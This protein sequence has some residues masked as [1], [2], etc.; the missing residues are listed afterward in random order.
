MVRERHPST[1]S[2]ED[3]RELIVWAVECCERLLP[4]FTAAVPDD[5]RPRTALDGALAF[6]RG[7]LRIGVARK[8]AASCHAAARAAPTRAAVAVARM[9]G[10]ATAVAHMGSHARGIPYY[11]H[12]ALPSDE[13]ETEVAWQRGHL[14]PHFTDFVY[15]DD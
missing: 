1:R 13:A 5:Q 4:L 7:E 9:C 15:P 10:H 6:G 11:T 2:E 3:R 8:L 14:P 12:K